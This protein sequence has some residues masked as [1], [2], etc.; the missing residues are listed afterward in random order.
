[1]LNAVGRLRRPD[2]DAA[3]REKYVT[4]LEENIARIETTVRRV[5]DL[6]PGRTTPGPVSLPE[7]IQ[8]VFDLVGFRASKK[9]V[10]LHL[11]VEGAVR[12]V[13]GDPNEIVQVFLNLVMNAIDATAAGGSVTVRVAD[14]DPWVSASVRDTG[15]GMTP[16]VLARAFDPFFTTK[17]AG[18]GTGLGLAIVHGVVTSL[19]GTI[20]VASEPG[21]GTTFTVLLRPVG[22]AV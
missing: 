13:L 16:E 21:K 6:T 20:E 2:L 19:G 17:E 12:K 3:A 9:G 14:Q 11:K 7:A 18:A 22:T 1:M 4:L 10:A 8:R 5:L 15:S